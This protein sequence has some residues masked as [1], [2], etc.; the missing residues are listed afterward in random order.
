MPPSFT[1]LGL[2]RI[3]LLRRVADNPSNLF[4]L[5]RYD[6]KSI[7]SVSAFAIAVH[8]SFAITLINIDSAVAKSVPSPLLIDPPK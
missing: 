6:I 2:L 1:L 8:H 3:S 7:G 4:P 5:S